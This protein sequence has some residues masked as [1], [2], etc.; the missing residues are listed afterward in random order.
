MKILSLNNIKTGLMASVVALSA[1]SCVDGSPRAQLSDKAKNNAI[2]YL[3]DEEYLQA[4]SNSNHESPTY[5]NK[6]VNYW[7]SINT[8]YKVKRAYLEGAQMVRDSITGKYYQKPEYTM[9]LELDYGNYSN[10]SYRRFVKKIINEVAANVDAKTINQ[11]IKNQPKIYSSEALLDNWIN[12]KG[13]KALHFWNNIVSTGKQ[14]KAFDD[15]ANAERV[16][17]NKE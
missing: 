14:R 8:E 17:L 2:E 3:T 7:D 12:K 16:K 1:V 9:P 15:G 6:L 13:W 5:P 4:E 10:D 11:L